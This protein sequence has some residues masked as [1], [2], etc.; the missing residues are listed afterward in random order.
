[1][2]DIIDDIIGYIYP[3]MSN[4]LI[5]EREV[6]R[7]LN[8]IFEKHDELDKEEII[9]AGWHF[10]KKP[11]KEEISKSDI[12]N[13]GIEIKRMGTNEII[14]TLPNIES[15]R[16]REE[17]LGK[18][19]EEARDIVFRKNRDYNDAFHR[20]YEEYGIL[21]ALIHLQ[22]KYERVKTLSNKKA[23][24]ANETLVDSLFDLLNYAV[25]TIYEL[26]IGNNVKKI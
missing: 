9:K 15:W 18:I 3:F 5:E 7:K 4:Y 12:S 25:L 6:R 17:K 13:D 11:S 23:V 1:M 22:E 16:K 20:L 10:T 21:L 14:A 2:E 24:V 26:R 8:A 19:Y